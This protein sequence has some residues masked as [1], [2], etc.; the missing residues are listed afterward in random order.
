MVTNVI[1]W[2]GCHLCGLAIWVHAIAHRPDPLGRVT[3][4]F[5]KTSQAKLAKVAKSRQKKKEANTSHRLANCPK[6]A[7]KQQTVATKSPKVV[8][9]SRSSLKVAE[10]GQNGQKLSQSGQRWAK[11]VK[12]HLEAS[13]KMTKL[14][15]IGQ[16]MTKSDQKC[17]KVANKKT[18]RAPKIGQRWPKKRLKVSQEAAKSVQILPKSGQTLPKVDK[19]GQKWETKVLG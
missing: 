1:A 7:R 9:S 18:H 2:G 16:N 13:K 8:K 12:R 14:T 11:V 15:K 5:Q 6:A 3:F 19:I 17:A 10:G 4:H